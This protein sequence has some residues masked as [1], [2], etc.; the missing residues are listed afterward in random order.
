M[1]KLLKTI[2]FS[3]SL[4]FVFSNVYAISID[5][6]ENQDTIVAATNLPNSG[7]STEA[8]FIS[9]VT[10]I[11]LAELSLAKYEFYYESEEPVIPTGDNAWVK[12]EGSDTLYAFDFGEGTDF[13][14]YL[15]KMGD[16]VSLVD[17][18]DIAAYSYDLGSFSLITP[19]EGS[20]T[21]YLY[22]NNESLRYALIDLADFEKTNGK[23]GSISITKIS[24]VAAPVPEPSTLLL[25]GSG[26]VGFALYRRKRK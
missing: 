13:S 16:N 11:D 18:A 14:Y 5:M 24:H 4:L 25:L 26:L 9:F 20:F 1:T 3:L 10:G 2:L 19:P 17:F 8:A 12:V 7:D 22:Q 6:V 21:D 23:G 15:V